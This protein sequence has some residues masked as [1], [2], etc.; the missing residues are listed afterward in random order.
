MQFKFKLVTSA[1]T[2]VCLSGVLPAFSNDAETILNATP[3]DSVNLSHFPVPFIY[4][5]WEKAVT[6][7]FGRMS[8]AQ[9]NENLYEEL[10]PTKD[11]EQPVPVNSALRSLIQS[12]KTKASDVIESVLKQ[13]TSRPKWS[14]IAATEQFKSQRFVEPLI[15]IAKNSSSPT[16]RAFAYKALSKYDSKESIEAIKYGLFDNNYSIQL[17][18]MNLLGD[19]RFLPGNML[20]LLPHQPVNPFQFYFLEEALKK[21]LPKENPQS[22]FRLPLESRTKLVE[23]AHP[24]LLQQYLD[25]ALLTPKRA[26]AAMSIYTFGN[27]AQSADAFATLRDILL[28]QGKHE[29]VYHSESFWLRCRIYEI[30]QSAKGVNREVLADALKQEVQKYSKDRELFLL[31]LTYAFEKNPVKDVLPALASLKDIK[32]DNYDVYTGAALSLA[33]AGDPAVFPSWLHVLSLKRQPFCIVAI[34]SLEGITGITTPGKPPDEGILANL[35][36][37]EQEMDPSKA[38]A[39]WSR[40]YAKNKGKLL[41]D[42]KKKRFVVR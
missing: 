4:G 33:A 19:K 24:G 5:D 11:E 27:R 8:L 14:V 32:T 3:K 12:N 28:E 29:D 30:W 39:F 18:C 17:L 22:F 1:L 31:A 7:R 10:P 42:T 2:L 35:G 34:R 37:P 13:N 6:A 9:Y 15:N 36:V 16:D 41:F 20:V 40:W 21:L 23:T 26:S 38:H 25:L